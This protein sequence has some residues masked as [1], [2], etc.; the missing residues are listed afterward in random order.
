M[1]TVLIVDDEEPVRAMLT[2]TLRFAGYEVSEAADGM[3]MLAHFDPASGAPVPDVVL[4]DVSMP[5]LD[6]FELVRVLRQRESDVPVL[7]LTARSDVDDRVRGLRAGADDYVTKP[8]SVAEVTARIEALLRRSG[9][10]PADATLRLGPLAL[11]PLTHRVTRDGEPVELS[12]TEYRLLEYL[13]RNADRVLSKSQLLA[14]VWGTGFGDTNVVERFVSS[15]RRKI[16]REGPSLIA[17]V[18][19]FGYAAR[20]PE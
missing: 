20:L 10:A 2:S 11:D 16:D 19:G 15:L 3:E 17:T 5:G 12:P 9:S 1:S 18:R 7:F 14:H 13:L 4:L 8:F 6:G